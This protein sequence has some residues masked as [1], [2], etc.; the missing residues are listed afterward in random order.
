MN[1]QPRVSIVRTERAEYPLPPFSPPRKFP[2][3]IHYW[4]DHVLDTQNMVYELIRNSWI[5]LGLD[6]EHLNTPNWNPLGQF[7][8][9]GDRVLIKP[10]LVFH[11]H[12]LGQPGIVSMMTHASVLRPIID[13][14]LIALKG[15]GHITVGDVALQSA[16]WPI[17]LQA[18][19]LRD[20][21]QY[22]LDFDQPVTT[23]DLRPA[24][25]ISNR[26]GI[27]T[28]HEKL[29]GDP[30]G[31]VRVDLGRDSLLQPVISK[32]KKLMITD[33]PQQAVSEHHN[34]QHNEY[35]IT[36]SALKSNVVINVPK[37]KTHKKSGVTLSMKNLIGING[38]KS[39]IAHHREGTTAEGGDES[40]HLT[41]WDKFRFR[42][43]V[44]LKYHRLG[45]PLL[46]AMIWLIE[47]LSKIMSRLQPNSGR[48]P[49]GRWRRFQSITEGSWYGND[50]LWR[51]ILDL[52][53][54]LLY[55][56][57][58]GYMHDTPQ[59]KTFQVI[60]GI[61]A[62]EYNGPMHQLPKPAGVI[63]VGANPLLT[64]TV[65][66]ELMGFDYRKIPQLLHGYDSMRY[67]IVTEP[68][69]GLNVIDQKVDMKFTD[70]QKKETFDFLPP[71]TWREKMEHQR[72][73]TN[74]AEPDIPAALNSAVGE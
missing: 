47:G 33:Y 73:P 53:R 19:G 49:L 61:M 44:N 10:N 25:S 13:Y 48:T 39:W 18:T 24:R 31:Y 43:F 29:P 5:Q 54:I 2:E 15:R 62:G 22:Y 3:L 23:V 32:Y 51:V 70:W 56:D 46:S 60:D 11:K 64:D 50:T 38:D 45:I 36:G 9:P 42:I 59:R 72:R 65:S 63:V 68:L 69:S 6:H 67:P 26:Y 1:L 7:I 30:D 28:G 27:I 41:G 40:P 8:Q 58:Q 21:Q 14:A 37:L 35:L 4:P 52:N 17:I 66:A 12:P 20:L 55:A 34:P 74:Q 57:R 16:D 71:H